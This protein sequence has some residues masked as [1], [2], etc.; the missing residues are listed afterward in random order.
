MFAPSSDC[1]ACHNNLVAPAGE[2]VSIGASWRG[3]IMANAARDPYLHASVRRETI[4]HPATAADIED[5]CAACHM[6]AAHADRA[7]PR[8]RKAQVF[9]H[10]SPARPVDAR[11]LD[12]LATDGV[13]CTVCHQIAADRLGT[14]ES[15]N[16]NF[17]VAAAAR[18]RHAARVRAVRARRRPAP[19]H[20]LGDRIRAG[21]GAAHP[22]VRA[23]RDL[24]HADHGGARAR[25]AAVIGSLPEQMN[26][27][28]WRH[29]AF[30]GGA[31]QLPV[32]PHAAG[33]RARCASSSVLGD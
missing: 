7:R 1:L 15:F 17:V 27:Q 25:T 9:A 13:T 8:A 6:P 26:Y 5:E 20:A 22:R 16:G 23:V 11:P 21:A 29:S 2:D 12:E 30:V 10:L 33:R 32:V 28:E 3:T 18:R 31:A 19:H 14:P 4:D 24:P